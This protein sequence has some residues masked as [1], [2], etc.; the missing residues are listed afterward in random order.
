MEHLNIRNIHQFDCEELY[1]WVVFNAPNNSHFVEIGIAEGKSSGYLGVE[2]INSNKNIRLDC[3]DCWFMDTDTSKDY[4][5][6]V[7]KNLTP[8]MDKMDIRIIQNYSRIAS[9][10][11]D[12]E[13]LDFVFIDGDHSYNGV[14]NDIIDWLPK[15]KNTGIIAGHDYNKDLYSH[16]VIK[17]VDDFFGKEIVNVSKNSWY[18]FIK[19]VDIK[20]HKKNSLI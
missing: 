17:A 14:T 10:G 8:I 5:E 12:N 16:N 15:L 6:T 1:K 2:I 13:S 20:K 11:Y 7:R 18:V 9:K 4:T 3:I 19:D